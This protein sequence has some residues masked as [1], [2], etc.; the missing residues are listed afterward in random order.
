MRLLLHWYDVNLA[1]LT[2][3]RASTRAR[4]SH[5]WQTRGSSPQC[6]RG[7]KTIEFFGFGDY[8]SHSPIVSLRQLPPHRVEAEFGQTPFRGVKLHTL[9]I[10][11]YAFALP[12]QFYIT[13]FVLGASNTASFGFQ[14][15]EA[16]NVVHE[17]S[18][19][20]CFGVLL[21]H[22]ILV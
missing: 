2:L 10:Q 7:Q 15:Q 18:P 13:I 19:L 14:F 17:K 9:P 21:G 6:R 1:R 3:P 11:S 16:I 22:L 5:R 12:E 20:V 4:L 8:L